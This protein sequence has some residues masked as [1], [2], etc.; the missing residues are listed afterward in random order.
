MRRVHGRGATSLYPV[1]IHYSDVNSWPRRQHTSIR[2]LSCVDNLLSSSAYCTWCY[3][4]WGLQQHILGGKM[5]VLTHHNMIGRP[6]VVV[7]KSG[8]DRDCF[9]MALFSDRDLWPL[10]TQGLFFSFFSLTGFD[11]SETQRGYADMLRKAW[12]ERSRSFSASGPQRTVPPQSPGTLLREQDAKSHRVQ[13]GAP[14]IQL[15]PVYVSQSLSHPSRRAATVTPRLPTL[16]W[17][18]T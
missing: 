9:Q 2:P 12:R 7:A 5:G 6:V 17:G 1:I 10:I 15:S 4:C 16:K 11:A 3:T 13:L 8:S 18:F 14:H